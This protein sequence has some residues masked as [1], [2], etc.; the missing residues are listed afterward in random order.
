MAEE[1]KEGQRQTASDDQG[2]G[3]SA[4]ELPPSLPQAQIRDA[5]TGTK[6]EA[7]GDGELEE[8][9][10]ASS[11]ASDIAHAVIEISSVS[12]EDSDE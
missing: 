12:S 2:A 3:G 4:A 11:V 7:G 10:E 1:R 8:G 5:A 6:G 9:E